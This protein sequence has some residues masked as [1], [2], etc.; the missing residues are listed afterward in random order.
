M[1]SIR[2][3]WGRFGDS[4]LDK[5]LLGYTRYGYSWRGLGPPS[6]GMDGKRIAV[7]GATS[8]LG[9]AAATS[10]A[11]AGASLVLIGRNTV[12]LER[13]AKRLGRWSPEVETMSAD[14]AQ[15][16]D[17]NAMA[18]RLSE[19]PG[20]LHCLVLNAGVLQTDR[21]LDASGF[22]QAYR[23]NLLSQYILLRAM[24]HKL[25]AAAGGRA[26]LVSSGGMFSEKLDPD[27]LRTGGEEGY[28]GVRH[29][30]Q[31]KRAQVVMANGWNRHFGDRFACLVMHPGWADT[32]GVERSLPRF[33][34]WTKGW[35]R[36][37]EQGADTVVWLSG[38]PELEDKPCIW[39]D[40]KPRPVWRM[41]STRESAHDRDRMWTMLESH[42]TG[43]APNT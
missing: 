23:V 3:L 43:R 17:V 34:R 8:G 5:S 28:D 12:K 15:L 1:K 24:R 31:T 11:K 32:P 38:I 41:A 29:Y 6:D 21:G 14:L 9:E 26:I 40:R 39:H 22:A 13:L 33:H 25:N 27:Y 2:G 36:T 16:G 37:P 7:T 18:K 35:L 20:P 30:A 42:C 4:L 10:L 19:S